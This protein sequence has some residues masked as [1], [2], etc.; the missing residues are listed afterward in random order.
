MYLQVIQHGWISQSWYWAKAARNLH[1]EWVLKYIHSES[2]LIKLQN[3]GC[4]SEMETA[5]TEEP[6]VVTGVF[7]SWSHKVIK[8]VESLNN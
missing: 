1:A 3:T 2:M 7:S 5:A 4:I 8:W 6:Q